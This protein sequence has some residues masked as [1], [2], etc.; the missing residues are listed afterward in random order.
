V[1]LFT[2]QTVWRKSSRSQGQNDDC[3]ELAGVLG[4]VGVR[5]SKNRA[6]GHL[7]LGGT[8]WALLRRGA[9][10]GDLDVMSK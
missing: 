5:D 2:S 9:L 1:D 6:R 10:S 8:T 7:V 3:V 4:T